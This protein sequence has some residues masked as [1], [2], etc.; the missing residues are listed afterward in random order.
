MLFSYELT[1]KDHD[2]TAVFS[3]CKRC[4]GAAMQVVLELLRSCVFWRSTVDTFQEPATLPTEI[5]G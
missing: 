2:C 1:A 5:F 3:S 4:L